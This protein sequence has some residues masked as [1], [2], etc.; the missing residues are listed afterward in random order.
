MS[1]Q[2]AVEPC[3][4]PILQLQILQDFLAYPGQFRAKQNSNKQK[5]VTE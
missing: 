2:A 1:R 4:L 5:A 3:K